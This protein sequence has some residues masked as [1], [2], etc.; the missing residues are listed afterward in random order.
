MQPL[1]LGYQQIIALLQRG[2][3]QV[4]RRVVCI[5]SCPPNRAPL[6]G[7]WIKC[8]TN[9]L[10]ELS[11]HTGP[12][13]SAFQIAVQ[14]EIDSGGITGFQKNLLPKFLSLLRSKS[15]VEHIETMRTDPHRRI[16]HSLVEASEGEVE[17]PQAPFQLTD[18][19]WARI[20][21]AKS[22]LRKFTYGI[23]RSSKTKNQ[24]TSRDRGSSIEPTYE[25][26]TSIPSN[27]RPPILRKIKMHHE[28]SRG[29]FSPPPELTSEQLANLKKHVI[30]LNAGQFST[31]GDFTT[32]KQEVQAIFDRHIFEWMEAADKEDLDLVFYSH[33]GLTNE[34]WGLATA[35][36]QVNWWKANGVYPIFFVWETGLLETIWQL[37][38]GKQ[39]GSRGIFDSIGNAISEA[40][41][42]VWETL[43]RA[44]QVPTLWSG[45]KASADLSFDDATGGAGNTVLELLFEFISQI[46]N[47]VR[48]HAVG[49]SAGSIFVS[50]MIA[51]ANEYE[52]FP[53]FE[54]G[55]FLAPA[56]SNDLFRKTLMPL[57][58]RSDSDQLKHLSIFTMN[59]GLEKKD[60]VG[61]YGKS[62]LYLIYHALEA[63]K[64]T[65]ILGLQHSLY[66]ERDIADFF[67]L[68]GADSNLTDV[69]F[70]KT[71]DDAPA[72]S[73]SDSTTHGGFDDDAATMESVLRRI[74]KANDNQSVEPF[75]V[76]GSRRPTS[77]PHNMGSFDTGTRYSSQ[78]Q[79]YSTSPPPSGEFQSNANRMHALCIGINDYPKVQDRLSGCESDAEQWSQW[80]RRAGFATQKM[81]SA[82]ATRSGIV[83]AV[84]RL[85][86]E[87]NLGDVVVIQYAGH[88]TQV[89]DLN[90]DEKQDE[91]L[92]PVD[93]AQHGLLRDDDLG[94]LC[95]RF[96]EGVSL[97]L[98]M[99][100]CCSGSIS[101][102]FLN[103]GAQPSSSGTS[104]PRCIVATQEM[105][106][107][108]RLARTNRGGTRASLNPYTGTNEILFAACKSN[109]YAYETNG[110][111]DFTRRAIEILIATGGNLSCV[112]F[113]RLIRQS[114]GVD[115]RQTPGLWCDPSLENSGFLGAIER[116]NTSSFG[117]PQHHHAANS[118]N[119]AIQQVKR[120]VNQF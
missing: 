73:C 108:D 31:D 87:S 28:Q 46:D 14:V 114:F 104:K 103:K 83:A 55:H 50:H 19:D 92:V 117:G 67:G 56:I 22:L 44:A 5:E 76:T 69:I 4:L 29:F 1:L 81:N 17:Q 106:E 63:E 15:G 62:L 68:V 57:I 18:I 112:E 32:S 71:P 96:K 64:R 113:M 41:D 8:L 38:Q 102:F 88:G 20:N 58:G 99:D 2:D 80:F 91:A 13:S 11:S 33:G 70:S 111:G 34:A 48:L 119:D 43:F 23:D 86:N 89:P 6:N 35:H 47:E 94:E 95:N 79:A 72:K 97:T 82:A 36:H 30:N 16:L 25:I 12:V 78:S 60:T 118:A 75:P 10:F 120:I 37:I 27:P 66:A 53:K 9:G 59:D 40:N 101:R 24:K 105:I 115:A 100:C 110:S 49:H 26:K 3:F 116:S 77:I 39:Q 51:A 65:H 107:A 85:I 54:T 98:I 90:G 74:I 21:E 84:E 42:K 45:M 7:L 93:Y 52:D 109:E 61:P